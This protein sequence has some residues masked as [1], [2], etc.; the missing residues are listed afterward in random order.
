MVCLSRSLL[1]YLFRWVCYYLFM[2][3]FSVYLCSVVYCFSLYCTYKSNVLNFFSQFCEKLRHNI[4]LAHSIRLQVYISSV[5]IVT[6]SNLYLIKGN[7]DK[8][9]YFIVEVSRYNAIY[10]LLYVILLKYG[11]GDFYDNKTRVIFYGLSCYFML[12]KF[13]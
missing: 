4:L 12:L 5:H 11:S 9:K 3:F 1:C 2:F 8:A 6:Y 10:V 13:G 7:E